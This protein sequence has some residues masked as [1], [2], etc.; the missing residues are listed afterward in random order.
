[1]KWRVDP[2]RWADIQNESGCEIA[3]VYSAGS[4]GQEWVI[5]GDIP[6]TTDE[7]RDHARLIAAAPELLEALKGFLKPLENEDD[8]AAAYLACVVAA[9]AAIRKATE[10]AS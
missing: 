10:A 1:M 8:L 3:S 4:A 2:E 5:T 9:E 6:W 7:A